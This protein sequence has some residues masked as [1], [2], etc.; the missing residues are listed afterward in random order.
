MTEENIK[1]K[2]PA[3][4]LGDNEDDI[5]ITDR[6]CITDDLIPIIEISISINKESVMQHILEWRP[7]WNSRKGN[8]NMWMKSQIF[9]AIDSKISNYLSDKKRLWFLYDD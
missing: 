1:V 2:I 8:T 3:Y 5:V 9:N 6:D 4:F 7:Y